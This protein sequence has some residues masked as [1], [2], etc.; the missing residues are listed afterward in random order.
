[1][2]GLQV[3]PPSDA[4]TLL[5]QGLFILIA[6][7][8][9]LSI[10]V[11]AAAAPLVRRRY[12][13]RVLRLMGLNHV[14]SLP[15]VTGTWKATQPLSARPRA[16]FAA[17]G[18]DGLAALALRRE[19]RVTRATVL[20]W[21]T[22]AGVAA[23][24]EGLYPKAGLAQCLAFFAVAALLALG[25]A[26]SN[27]PGRWTRWSLAI[28]FIA[29]VLGY[30]FLGRDTSGPD[31]NAPLLQMILI[32]LAIGWAYVAMFHRRLRGQ[33]LPMFVVLSICL[34]LWLVPCAYLEFYAGP[35]FARFTDAKQGSPSL[36]AA[37]LIFYPLC[38]FFLWV[39]FRLLDALERLIRRGL[40]SE[41]SLGCVVSLT[42][43]AIA[44]LAA[45]GES[46]GI[47]WDWATLPWMAA[48][49]GMYALALGRPPDDSTGPQLLVLR[50]FSKDTDK[51]T[52]L[53]EL[54]ARWRYVGAVHEIGGPDMVDLNVNPYESLM[55]LSN[56]LHELFL[57]LAP[58]LAQL[59]ARLQTAPDHEGRYRINE[60]FC[61]NTAW[62]ST[63]DQL[64]QL[65]DAIVLDLRGLT[66]QRQGTVYEIRLLA[67]DALLDKVVAVVDDS[68][69][70]AHVDSLLRAEG[71]NP[72][73]LMRLSSDKE[74]QSQELFTKLLQVAAR[75]PSAS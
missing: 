70:W 22:F 65:S 38:V 67:R 17:Y 74:L 5:S 62:H 14:A 72:R 1:M 30:V 73:R 28:G 59:K 39:A 16:A 19:H 3:Q 24:V 53:D 37:Q 31:A 23:L 13:R 29:C 11:A 64:M 69:D 75:P 54:Q 45:G 36:V 34:L 44:M 6:F 4:D 63:V 35:W 48:T 66:A 26:L 41:L 42:L 47:W 51:Q 18:V 33:V 12:R 60:V 20:A 8:Q 71:G 58:S 32:G 52:L 2:N 57:P 27:L 68:T 21:L 55:F 15:S 25:P 56:R 46:R 61:F 40:V 50:V 9:L 7:V 49:V 10:M 43:I